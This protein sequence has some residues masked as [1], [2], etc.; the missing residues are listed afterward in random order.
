MKG[1]PMSDKENLIVI[2]TAEE[3]ETLKLYIQDK[4]IISFDTET[5]GV[6]KDSEII[7]FSVCA[8]PNLAFY[9]ILAK[10]IVEEV[11]VERPK[12]TRKKAKDGP[13]EFE[14][15]KEL[16]GHLE[17]TECKDLATDFFKLLIGKSLIAHNAVF[18]CA[19]IFNN[20]KVELMP[21]VYA[22][23]MV[24]GH[25]LDE[26]RSNGLKELGV[27]IFGLNAKKEQNEV[28]ESVSR[29]GGALTRTNYE[30]YKADPYII[31]KYGAKDTLLT[32]QLFYHFLPILE[33]EGLWD[34]FFNDESMPLLRGPT[35]DLNTVGLRLDTEKLQTLKKS[36]EAECMELNAFVN[37]EI[38]QIVK[39]EYPG[40]KKTNTFN[41]GS[42][43]QLAWLLFIKLDNNFNNLTKEGRELCKYFDMKLPYSI[44]GK[45]QFIEQCRLNEGVKWRE[46]VTDATS[47][48]EKGSKK[49]GKPWNY[50]AADKATLK[51][52]ENKYLWVKKLLEYTKAKKILNTYVEG[53]QERARYGVIQPSF[54][55]IG[56][57]S[58]RYSCIAEGQTVSMPGGDKPIEQVKV[59]DL[60]YCYTDDGKPTV[61][62]VKKVYDNGLQD[63]IELTWRSKGTHKNG[64]LV[65]T[66]DH[67]IKT[68]NR[69]W[70]EAK[71]LELE[72]SVFHLRRG[73]NKVGDRFRV[74]GANYY[75]KNEEQL[76]KEEFFKAPSDFHIHHK[77]EDKADNR[78]ENLEVLSHE[79]HTSLHAKEH[80]KSG[81]AKW[82]HLRFHRPIRKSGPENPI[83][84]HLTRFKALRM[85]AKARGRA[86]KVSMDFETFKQK[87]LL[88]EIDLK[89]VKDRYTSSGK[90]ITKSLIENAVLTNKKV[91]NAAKHLGVS[92][93]KFKEL[94][95]LNGITYNH[96]IASRTAVGSRRVYDLE[97][98]E[99]HNFIVNEICVHNCKHPNFQNLPRDDK[100]VKACIISRPG[101]VFVGSDYSQLEPRVFASFSK[102]KRLLQSF[103]DKHDFYSIIGVEVFNKKDC[104]LIKDD[105]D[106]DFFGNK[107]KSL[108][109]ISKG[110]ALSATYGTTAPK[111]A[112]LLNIEVDEAKKIIEGYFEKFPS[113]E[114]MMLESHEL[115]KRDGKVVNLFGR[116][117]R[118]P[119]AKKINVIY[120][121]SSH[122][123]LPYEA[124]NLLNLAVNHRIQST[125]ASIVNRAAI[126]FHLAVKELNLDA[127][128][129]LQVHDEIVFECK[130]ED[131]EAVASLLKYCMEETVTL[132][133]IKLEA[134]PKIANNLA[135]LK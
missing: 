112:G 15:V 102:D 83:Y 5:T 56:T 57:S 9:V 72:E 17:Y 36:L 116:P 119:E 92:L 62:R 2:E 25:L 88:L 84:I 120:G 130:A 135:D 75:M 105:N 106:P 33:E 8:E 24:L 66:P 13:E 12:K 6:D 43:K 29:N 69:G 45:I 101:R 40:T 89:A 39:D 31:G 68:R 80:I 30:L 34:F 118:M 103:L 54:L 41:I 21:S 16:S 87:C 14:M 129:V 4:D 19:M 123:E 127:K 26:N 132:P 7:G 82:E 23:T 67:R 65:C 104:N 55:Q 133:G 47:K 20:F 70:V 117:R 113:V 97:V 61:S 79:A 35:Y 100:R 107:Y 110:V 115:A 37:K 122:S 11:T 60:V 44:K 99:Y 59:G 42:S 3:L 52:L 64:T 125:A 86:V 10:W 121:N 94:C 51:K 49:V 98:E 128:I 77:N 50:L 48:K 1:N 74:Y 96:K 22:D 124:R 32:Y 134:E 46:G 131:A 38:A 111:L 28:K 109:D 95:E 18:D 90:Y 91:R 108:R 126:A 93:Y 78:I 58:G 76:I 81:R 53:I 27:S 63:C 73:K 71:D 85:L 114:L